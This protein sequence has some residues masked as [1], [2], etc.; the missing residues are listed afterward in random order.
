V[1]GAVGADVV[2]EFLC[3]LS[4]VLVRD[5]FAGSVPVDRDVFPGFVEGQAGA[6]DDVLYGGFLLVVVVGR[7]HAAPDRTRAAPGCRS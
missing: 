2:E 4:D 7:R 3:L 5:G 1:L 6:V